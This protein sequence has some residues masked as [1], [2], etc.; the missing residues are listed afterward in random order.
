MEI[1]FVKRTINVKIVDVLHQTCSNT[2]SIKVFQL[3]SHSW[4]MD[5]ALLIFFPGVMRLGL[6]KCSHI[7]PKVVFR[8]MTVAAESPNKYCLVA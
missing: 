8:Q 1:L 6:I 7:C 2:S 3:V 4:T 5:T